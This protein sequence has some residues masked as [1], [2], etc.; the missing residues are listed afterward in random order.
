LLYIETT[1]LEKFSNLQ[2]YI[3]SADNEMLS[4]VHPQKWLE[5][6]NPPPPPLRDLIKALP[7]SLMH[8]LRYHINRFAKQNN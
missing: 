4:K 5:A 1:H 3:V 6:N 2:K 7:V 8:T